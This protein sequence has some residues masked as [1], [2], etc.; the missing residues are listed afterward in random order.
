[1]S[2]WI[3]VDDRLPCE[4]AMYIICFDNKVVCEASFYRCPE[5]YNFN[6]Q[7]PVTFD[8]IGYEECITHW[9]PLPEPP[10]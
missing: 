4:N 8:N 9:M 3:S 6:W 1:M 7:C 10:K 2:E 5:Y